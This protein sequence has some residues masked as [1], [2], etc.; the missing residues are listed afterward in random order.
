MN[1]PNRQYHPI[2][3]VNVEDFTAVLKS[4]H[5]GCQWNPEEQ[6]GSL[7]SD[8]HWRNTTA[9]FVVGGSIQYRVCTSCARSPKWSAHKQERIRR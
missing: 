7:V 6:R 8:S 3:P 5:D 9:A 4:R 2:N 1:E